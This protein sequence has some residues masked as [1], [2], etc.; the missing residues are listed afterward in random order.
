MTEDARKRLT[1]HTALHME[2]PDNT[3]GA[4]RNPDPRDMRWYIP[5]TGMPP[6]AKINSVVARTGQ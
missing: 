6:T 1:I 3:K 4:E 5:G 2:T